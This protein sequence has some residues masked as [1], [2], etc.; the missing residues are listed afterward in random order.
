MLAEGPGVAR[1]EKKFEQKSLAEKILAYKIPRLPMSV[2][3]KISA[4]SVQPLGRL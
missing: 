2:H 4:Q 3:K 1:K